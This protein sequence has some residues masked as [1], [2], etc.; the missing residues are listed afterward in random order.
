MVSS[1]AGHSTNMT[2]YMD[3]SN[4]RSRVDMTVSTMV[5]ESIT[6][7]T[8]SAAE[9]CTIMPSS[10]YCT[11]HSSTPPQPAGAGCTLP[12]YNGHHTV[13]GMDTEAWNM[14]CKGASG[15]TT[16]EMFWSGTTPVEVQVWGGSG[17][18]A[19]VDYYNWNPTEPDASLFVLPSYCTTEE[20]S[21]RMSLSRMAVDVTNALSRVHH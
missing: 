9:G 16:I 5:M 19:Q 11:C 2:Y 1:A 6:T 3:G 18:S 14:T 20:Q 17:M 13:R 8:G 4:N 12:M 21:R 15:S 7:W 10:S